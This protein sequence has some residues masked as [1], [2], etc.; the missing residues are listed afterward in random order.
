MST[1]SVDSRLSALAPG[2]APLD[3]RRLDAAHAAVLAAIPGDHAPAPVALYEHDARQEQELRQE[4]DARALRFD[5]ARQRRRARGALLAA[6]CVVLGVAMVLGLPRGGDSPAFATWTSSAEPVDPATVADEITYCA[7]RA[8]EQSAP[9]DPVLLEQRGDWVY[10][11]FARA[12]G[13][14]TVMSACLVRRTGDAELAIEGGAVGVEGPW[15]RPAADEVAPVFSSWDPTWASTGGYAGDEVARVVLSV[16]RPGRDPR[17]VVASV[18]DGWFGA[19]WPQ[20]S[21]HARYSLTWY[22]RDGTV[23][24]T[25]DNQ[26]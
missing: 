9:A 10:A 11:M 15:E 25:L 20:D 17:T 2:P 8:Q 24:G 18:A 22:L 16:D 19:W 7:V 1:P 4:H 5:R 3:P 6:A 21:Q 12:S 13:T 26:R 14:E 23:G